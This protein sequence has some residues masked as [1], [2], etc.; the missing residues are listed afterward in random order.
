LRIGAAKWRADAA[1]LIALFSTSGRAR[2]RGCARF[3]IPVAD[4]A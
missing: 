3:P 1:I 2:I 4:R